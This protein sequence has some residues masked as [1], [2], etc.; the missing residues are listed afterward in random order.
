MTMEEFKTRLEQA[1]TME[2]ANELFL[3]ARRK[4]IIKPGEQLELFPTVWNRTAEQEQAAADVLRWVETYNVY[5]P[6]GCAALMERARRYADVHA[7][8]LG[9]I[10][11][12]A[13]LTEQERADVLADYTAAAQGVTHYTAAPSLM[14]KAVRDLSPRACFA[15]DRYLFYNMVF[16][17]YRDRVQ[18]LT[19]YAAAL[20]GGVYKKA[21]FVTVVVP[22]PMADAT[23]WAIN[24]G[25]IDLAEFA[26]VKALDDPDV[27]G[28]DR[29]ARAADPIVF[30][31]AA[32][33]Y[34]DWARYYRFVWFAKNALQ[35]TVEELESVTKPPFPVEVEDKRTFETSTEAILADFDTEDR[36]AAETLTV[37]GVAGA[38]SRPLAAFGAGGMVEYKLKDS[39]IIGNSLLS[40]LRVRQERGELPGIMYTT[41]E[42]VFKGVNLYFT[43]NRFR[44]E[45]GERQ[46]T[47]VYN[48]T[49]T[50]F[51]RQCGVKDSNQPFREHLR[52]AMSLLN[53]VQLSP[54]VYERSPVVFVYRQDKSKDDFLEIRV[55]PEYIQGANRMLVNAVQVDKLK[56]LGGRKGVELR[57]YNLTLTRGHKQEDDILKQIYNYDAELKEA[58]RQDKAAKKAGQEAGNVRKFNENWRKHL[59]GRRGKLARFFAEARACGALYWFEYRVGKDGAVYTWDK[60][61]KVEENRKLTEAVQDGRK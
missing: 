26:D 44:L 9:A 25:F 37:E 38:I 15:E 59:K 54:R 12:R 33:L 30:G 13:K 52:A 17:G 2:E 23:V 14:A 48:T 39:G 34:G 56:A 35:A 50:D 49:F 43:A 1:Q 24:Y 29:N 20:D 53:A 11:K 42:Q 8:R 7:R 40:L 61:R 6:T 27:V 31:G 19:K 57:F 55:L 16:E 58:E 51:A 32:R 36:L 18:E 60:E 22:L 4:R 3:T 47:L 10:L 5:V 28:T 45:K 21:E 41:V 46:D